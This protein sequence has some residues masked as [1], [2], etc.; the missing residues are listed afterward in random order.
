MTYMEEAYAEMQQ[1]PQE[2]VL[3]L[4]KLMRA[5]NSNPKQTG[6]VNK[7]AACEKLKRIRKQNANL[8]PAGFDFDAGS[9]Q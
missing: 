6:H 2:S 8:Y 7:K 3:A 1:L 4:L 5:I 9:V